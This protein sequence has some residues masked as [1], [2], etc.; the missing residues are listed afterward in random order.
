M[1]NVGKKKFKSVK[2]AKKFAKQTGKKMVKTK[3]KYS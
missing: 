2:K 1:P 3:R